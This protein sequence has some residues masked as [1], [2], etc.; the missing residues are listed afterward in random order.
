M[1][2]FWVLWNWWGN[3]SL[4]QSIAG[5]KESTLAAC[6]G[7][8]KISSSKAAWQH[9]RDTSVLS[10]RFCNCIHKGR[11][12]QNGDAESHVL[13]SECRMLHSISAL[14]SW[15][16]SLRS[17]SSCILCLCSSL[18]RSQVA[19]GW[20][21]MQHHFSYAFLIFLPPFVKGKLGQVK[22]NVWIK[23]RQ[24]SRSQS[25][26]NKS[27]DL[28]YCITTAACQRGGLH[29]SP[30]PALY[31]VTSSTITKTIP[32]DKAACSSWDGAIPYKRGGMLHT[33]Y[34]PRAAALFPNDVILHAAIGPAWPK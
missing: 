22:N 15:K 12:G 8:K 27:Q 16:H 33:L 2:A 4:I 29:T 32:I 7:K 19:R 34:Q 30:C 20:A 28:W 25:L 6:R 21:C 5:A 24:I 3:C 14:V 1:D 9:A 11:I 23:M 18:R 17:P 10:C 13:V 26:M 31:H